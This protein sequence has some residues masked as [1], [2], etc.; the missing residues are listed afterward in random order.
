MGPALRKRNKRCNGRATARVAPTK[1]LQG[2]QERAESPSHGCVVPAPF[3]QGGLGDG[4]CG[5]P[6]ALCALAMTWFLQGVR[7]AAGHMGPALRKRNKRCNGRATARVAPTKA[8]Q[9]VQERAESPSHGCVVPAPFRQGGLGDGGCGLPRAL[10]ALAMTWFL[11]GVR[12]A[13][14]HMGPALRKRNKR[15][16]GRATARVAPTKALQGGQ[17]RAE[18]PS[19][20]FAVPAPFR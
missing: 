9:G 20:G 2:V 5:L 19:H 15:C 10:C 3:R 11:Q 8:L 17:G 7:C 12:C 6:R 13:A 1:A 14:G 18:S 16:N 4:G